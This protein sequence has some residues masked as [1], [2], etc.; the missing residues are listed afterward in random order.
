MVNYE[1]STCITYFRDTFGFREAISLSRARSATPVSSLPFYPNMPR[2]HADIVVDELAHLLARRMSLR[3]ERRLGWRW[4]GRLDR[5][6]L[7]ASV[8]YRSS[9]FAGKMKVACGED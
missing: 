7:S 5:K 3:A 2:E 8:R 6:N 4:T 1:R 9:W